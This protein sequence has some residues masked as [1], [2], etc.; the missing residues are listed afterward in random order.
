LLEGIL[1]SRIDFKFSTWNSTN[2]QGHDFNQAVTLSTH[3]P[4]SLP[5]KREEEMT[6]GVSI[7]NFGVD[8]IFFFVYL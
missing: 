2:F 3:I 6:V 7:F 1:G 4:H 8:L 5:S